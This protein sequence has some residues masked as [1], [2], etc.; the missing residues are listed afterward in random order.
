MQ[1]YLL[2]WTKR[3]NEQYPFGDFVIRHKFELIHRHGGHVRQELYLNYFLI[4]MISLTLFSELHCHLWWKRAKVTR[5]YGWIHL[6][7]KTRI[8]RHKGKSSC[9]SFILQCLTMCLQWCQ[10]AFPS[11]SQTQDGAT[12]RPCFVLL[13]FDLL[14]KLL[15][16]H[17][18]LNKINQENL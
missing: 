3:L 8:R 9:A 16:P 6:Q 18:P 7:K 11:A 10:A 17:S 12:G 15:T 13:L 4:Q 14:Q 5:L 2:L 1:P